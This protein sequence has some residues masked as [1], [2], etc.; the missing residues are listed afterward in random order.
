M[1][2]T[3]TSSVT[4]PVRAGVAN[5]WNVIDAST[6]ESSR[7]IEADVVI[8][9]T[10]AGGGVT[11]EI[12]ADAGFNVVLIEEGPLKSST[13]FRMREAE[14][15]PELYQESAAR[16]TKDKAI[17]ILQGRCVGGGTTVNWTSS[18]RTPPAT[19]MYW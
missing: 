9:G 14:A 19:L 11:A 15:Y 16:K 7:T 1:T 18:F 8:V 4:D 17:S 2:N 6:L 10:G 3:S 5:G 12:L 13:D